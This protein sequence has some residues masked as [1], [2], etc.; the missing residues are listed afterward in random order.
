MGQRFMFIMVIMLNLLWCTACQ[1]ADV[2]VST[3]GEIRETESAGAEEDVPTVT[4][5]DKPT[6][7][8]PQPA[9]YDYYIEELDVTLTIPA[10]LYVY[11]I[12]GVY[13]DWTDELNVHDFS[14]WIVVTDREFDESTL[15]DELRDNYEELAKHVIWGISLVSKELWPVQQ[16][17]QGLFSHQGYRIAEDVYC[18]FLYTENTG[19]REGWPDSGLPRIIDEAEVRQRKK[20]WDTWRNDWKE[21]ICE[22]TLD[23]PYVLGFGAPLYGNDLLNEDTYYVTIVNEDMWDIYRKAVEELTTNAYKYQY[24]EAVVKPFVEIVEAAAKNITYSIFAAE[25]PGPA[26]TDAQ[27]DVWLRAY[28]YAHSMVGKGKTGL[29]P[30]DEDSL[31]NVVVVRLDWENGQKS[32]VT[33]VNAESDYYIKFSGYDNSVD[34]TEA[35]RY[36]QEYGVDFGAADD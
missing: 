7:P 5:T 12:N 30:I 4:E 36:V 17:C 19:L 14:E 27:Q 24:D 16:M 13:Q 26:Y 33:Y 34:L 8:E 28:A 9:A 6:E 29:D 31:R 2:Q 18:R 1:P 10:E 22:K 11:R 23:S 25:R 32:H 3:D 15:A 20:Q 35:Y 21:K